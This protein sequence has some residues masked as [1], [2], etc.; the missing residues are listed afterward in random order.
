MAKQ[1]A[2]TQA[3]L[4][5]RDA[6]KR[7]MQVWIGLAVVWGVVLGWVVWGLIGRL[8]DDNST[9]A[10][11]TYLIPLAILV[12]GSLVAVARVRATSRELLEVAEKG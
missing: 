9:A 8:S 3:L 12:I 6:R 2:R 1:E 4:R 7:S 11:L 10:W 5:E